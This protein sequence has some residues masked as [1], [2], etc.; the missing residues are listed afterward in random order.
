MA[1]EGKFKRLKSF[2]AWVNR[3]ASAGRP[4]LGGDNNCDVLLE[5]QECITNNGVTWS[6]P[7]REKAA[8]ASKKKGAAQ[9]K[10]LTEAQLK[11]LA[12]LKGG[13]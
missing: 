11:A 10:S 2:P 7:K 12:K 5:A 6:L 8:A 4:L 9:K 1:D 13:K 3:L